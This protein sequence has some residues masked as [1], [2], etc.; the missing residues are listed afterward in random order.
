MI[1]KLYHYISDKR[2]TIHSFYK[3]SDYMCSGSYVFDDSIKYI[4]KDENHIKN[5]ANKILDNIHYRKM[6]MKLLVSILRN[7]IFKN[8]MIIQHPSLKKEAFSGTIFLPVGSTRSYR[9]QKIF[10]I[11][12]K[13][14]LTIY[15]HKEDYQTVLAHYAYFKEYF[16]VTSIY[17]K[18]DEKQLIMEEL[19]FFQPNKIWEEED[20]LYVM[21][22]VFHH[23]ANYLNTCKVNGLYSY[24][25]LSS[26]LESLQ[27]DPK[28]DY[29]KSKISPE[30]QSLPIPSVKLH[31]DLWTS[32]ILLMNGT[33]NQL[34]YIDWEF[35]NELYFFYDFFCMM[36]LEV[37]MK[38]NYIYIEKYV[39]GD[40]DYHF[41]Q[42]FSLFHLTFDSRLR[43]AYFH[44][45]FLAFYKER[46]IHFNE[47]D[48]HIYFIQY[49]KLIEKMELY[50]KM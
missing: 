43:N 23:Y 46:L 31:G 42:I 5:K 39:R 38:E 4:Y 32:N 12:N 28:I 36:W 2:E 34:K 30:L 40:Y 24:H 22:T 50:E 33:Q 47:E 45:F 18:D 49:K 3:Y 9:D 1:T 21:E 16:P 8:P 15:A 14:V 25:T 26:V 13:K 20:F 6:M 29:I 7:T 41:G 37:Y 10:D 44:I 27:D 19:I 11:K 35:S 48:K 17:W